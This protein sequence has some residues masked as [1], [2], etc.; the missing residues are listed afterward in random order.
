MKK[1]TLAR[2]LIQQ[3]VDLDPGYLSYPFRWFFFLEYILIHLLIASNNI[4]T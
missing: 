4:N 2:I 1:H 3:A